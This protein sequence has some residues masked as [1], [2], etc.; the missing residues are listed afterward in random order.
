VLVVQDDRFNLS[1]L[2]T[3]VVAALT[4]NTQSAEHPGNVFVPAS[5]S[6]LAKDSA[7]NVSQLVTLD[8][9]DLSEAVAELPSYLL[10]EV[11]AGIRLVL[12]V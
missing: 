2:S 4:S 5:A 7:V 10:S 11:D 1:G 3:V 9:S 6:G 12:S 8:K